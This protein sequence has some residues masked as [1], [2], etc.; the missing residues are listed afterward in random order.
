MVTF[1]RSN[2]RPLDRTA[3]R[4]RHLLPTSWLL[5]LFTTLFFAT[6]GCDSS[7]VTTDAAKS[8]ASDSGTNPT[9]VTPGDSSQHSTTTDSPIQL[10][11]QLSDDQLRDWIDQVLSY[12]ANRRRLNLQDHAAWQVIHGALAFGRD[13]R[14]LDKEGQDMVA[15]DYLLQG[16]T[17]TGWNL[18]PGV[19][20]GDP[21]RLGLR[22]ILEAGSKTG[23]GHADQWLGYL[24]DLGYSL[25]QEIIAGGH[26]YTVADYLRQIEHDVPYNGTQEY[27][28][29][30]MALSA[31]RPTTY[32]W[33]AGDGATW[34][35]E[36]LLEIEINHELAGSACGGSHRMTGITM[37]VAAR[38]RQNVPLAGVWRDA[39]QLIQQ[40]VENAQ[41]FR[42]P[43]G[44]LST[45]YFQRT[46]NS[47]DIKDRLA[48]TGHVL[49]FVILASPND[50]LREAWIRQAVIYLC[51]LLDKTRGVDLE[52][53]AL[54]HAARGLSLYRERRFGPKKNDRVSLASERPTNERPT[55]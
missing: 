3:P 45:N 47:A 28:W 39:N 38:R 20:L 25:D 10:S 49:E 6:P 52:C 29:T 35:I 14:I 41:N 15:L 31:Y 5:V 7:K 2:R 48:A 17:M 23:Q 27:S 32:E 36:R 54:Y 4:N 9:A 16:G 43:D 55:N 33:T 24:A 11:K 46:G 42:N 21:P 18:Q 34:S 50:A 22:A 51:Q 53:G 37:A 12:T 8:V 44:S 13:L 19:P 40:C 26:T 30:L 1:S